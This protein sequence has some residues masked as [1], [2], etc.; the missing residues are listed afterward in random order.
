MKRS[1]EREREREREVNWELDR[2]KKEKA[3]TLLWMKW[4]VGKIA[5]CKQQKYVLCVCVCVRVCECVCL[6]ESAFYIK[7]FVW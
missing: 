4:L 7:G 1:R 2:N 3:L 5:E 6:K